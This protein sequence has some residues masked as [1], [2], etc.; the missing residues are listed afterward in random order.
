MSDLL[1]AHRHTTNNRDEIDASRMCGCCACLRIFP[2]EEIV[3]WDGLEASS[4]DDPDSL[5][6]GTALCPSCGSDAVIG[7]HSGYPIEP[8]FLGRMNEAW[9][10]RTIIRKPAP[11]K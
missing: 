10:Q 11:K 5:I 2:A 6:G 1:A 4:F 9:Y 7:D 8:G 3:A